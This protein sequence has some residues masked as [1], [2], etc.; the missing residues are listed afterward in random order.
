M[1]LTSIKKEFHRRVGDAFNLVR[2]K[3]FVK[4]S[5]EKKF[6]LYSKAGFAGRSS[7]F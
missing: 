6:I 2:I 7:G 5:Y 3:F 4:R 1:D